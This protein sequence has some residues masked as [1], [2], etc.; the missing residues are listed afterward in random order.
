[1]QGIIKAVCISEKKGTEKRP[2]T[3]AHLTAQHGIDGD[4]HAGPWHRQVSLLSAEKAEEFRRRG[5][6]VQDGAFGENLL[7]KGIDFSSL[8]IG[9]V[10]TTAETVLRLTQIGKECHARCAIFQRVGS[11]IMPHEGVFAEVLRGGTIRP[12]EA[13]AVRLPEEG[14]EAAEC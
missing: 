12:G 3:S 13:L 11:C 6:E 7:V 14:G 9:T 10:F 1:M 2:V 5:A 4:A 8:P